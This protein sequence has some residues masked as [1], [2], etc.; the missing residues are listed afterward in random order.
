MEFRRLH[1]RLSVSAAVY[2][3]YCGNAR[4][5]LYEPSG[6]GKF[7]WKMLYGSGNRLTLGLDTGLGGIKASLWLLWRPEG[8]SEAAMRLI[9][10]I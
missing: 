10:A 1:T 5:S 2:R 9:V 4:F 3:S 8:I 7:P 6:G